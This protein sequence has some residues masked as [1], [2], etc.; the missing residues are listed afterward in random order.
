VAPTSP[1]WFRH[2]LVGRD[3]VLLSLLYF[4]YAK[5]D[6]YWHIEISVLAGAVVTRQHSGAP[7]RRLYTR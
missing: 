1:P 6:L 2:W 3:S 5:D 4:H 7:G